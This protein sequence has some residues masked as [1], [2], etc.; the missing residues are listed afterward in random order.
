MTRSSFSSIRLLFLLAAAAAWALPRGGFAAE[1]SDPV[2]MTKT[3]VVIAVDSKEPLDVRSDAKE[4]PPVITLTFPKRRVMGSLPERSSFAKGVVR[5]I[6]ARY[7]RSLRPRK[8]AKRFLHALQIGLSAPYPS[9]VRSEPGRVVIE[10]SHPH[11]IDSASMEVGLRGGTIAGAIGQSA[12]TQRFRAMQDALAQ[13]TAAPTAWAISF[14]AD[15]PQ[16]PAGGVTARNEAAAIPQSTATPELKPAAGAGPLAS[17]SGPAGP[18]R[19]AGRGPLVGTAILIVAGV[20]LGL[21]WLARGRPL[22]LSPGAAP[23][24]SNA[25]RLPSAALLVDQLIWRAFERRGYQLVQETELAQ[26]SPATLRVMAKDGAKAA[27]LFA[28]QGT[29]FEKQ[30]VERFVRTMEGAEAQQG[31]LA[32]AGSFT[33][34]AQRLAEQHQITLIGREQLTELLSLGAGSEYFAK[35]IE[36]SHARL[37]EAKETLRQYAGELETLRRQRNEASW[38]LGEERAQA[39]KLEAQLND[40]GQQIRRHEAELRQWEQEAATLRRRW[41][42]SQWYLGESVARVRHLETQLGALQEAA[43]RAETAE[44]ERQAL[45]GD[46]AKERARS[47][48]VEEQLGSLQRNL[49]ESAKRELALQMALEQLKQ[50]MRVLQTSGDRRVQA[51]ANI[52]QALVELFNGRNSPVFSGA[53][54]DVSSIGLGLETEQELPAGSPLRVRLTLPGR[55]PI[56][57]KGRIVWQQA[58]GRPRRYRSGCRLLRVPAATRALIGKALQEIPT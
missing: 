10:I 44:Q 43:K 24:P 6:A 57:S 47:E 58:S 37:E 38:Y 18:S 36:Q 25:P 52:P 29:F 13:A 51:R 34:P 3:I 1:T 12:M 2:T 40:V 19:S 15:G 49:E 32:A 54:R 53:P 4:R 48:A 17:A 22:R 28:G 33:V 27:L 50:E 7:D 42:E 35:Q 56:E 16:P 45:Q 41:E 26:P 30:T 9:Q 21:W 23:A 14:T 46:L 39:A 11:S 8:S 5:T 55:D 20:S 31:F